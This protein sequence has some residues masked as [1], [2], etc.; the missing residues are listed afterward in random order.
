M[1]LTDL[2]AELAARATESDDRPADLLAGTHRRITRVKRRRVAGAVAGAVAGTA[3]VLGLLLPGTGPDSAPEPAVTPKSDLVENGIRIPAQRGADRLEKAATGPVGQNA[4][5]FDWA[6]TTT[7]ITLATYC[8][9]TTFPNPVSAEVRINGQY[10]ARNPCDETTAAPDSLHA[11]VVRPDGTLWLGTPLGKDAR[12]TVALVDE[13]GQQVTDPEAQLGLGIYR[14]GTAGGP[15]TGIAPTSADDY[16]RDGIRYRATVGGATL[17]AAVVGDPAQTTAKVDFN[18]RGGELS[19]RDFCT[20]PYDG[21]RY[22]VSVAL[23]GRDV[24]TLGKCESDSTDAGAGGEVRIPGASRGLLPGK[25]AEATIRLT[26][27]QGRPVSAP[28]V[29]LGLG[30]YQPGPQ[31]ELDAG[32]GVAKIRLDEWAEQSGRLYKLTDVRTMDAARV[33]ANQK[34]TVPTP[35]GV[36]FLVAYGSSDLGTAPAEVRLSGLSQEPAALSS[37]RGSEGVGMSIAVEAARPAGAAQLYL[38]GG[39]PTKGRLFLAVYTLQR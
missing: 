5:Q 15:P 38:A 18:F 14:S 37:S 8:R 25:T 1:N 4:L 3:V 35:A 7:G 26:D 22:K 32:P 13:Q 28:G 39:K 21:P 20:T 24:A 16:V 11:T 10:V 12:I 31:R 30:I 36:A 2:R 17:A 23:N 6:P 19:L 33:A 27:E 34:L 29:R 9:S